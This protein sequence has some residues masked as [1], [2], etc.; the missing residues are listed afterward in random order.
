[1]VKMHWVLEI[2]FVGWPGPV[3]FSAPNAQSGDFVYIYDL[4][5]TQLTLISKTIC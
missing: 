1:M 2:N 3:G 5:L 4:V